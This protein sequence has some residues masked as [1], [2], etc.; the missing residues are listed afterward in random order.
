[1]QAILFNDY[2]ITISGT[3]RQYHKNIVSLLYIE[4]YYHYKTV[5]FSRHNF[6]VL[7]FALTKL[8]K[9]LYYK[10]L[11]VL[12]KKAQVVFCKA[13]VL[14]QLHFNDHLQEICNTTSNSSL[15]CIHSSLQ[16]DFFCNIYK[17]IPPSTK[18]SGACANGVH[19]HDLK[20]NHFSKSRLMQSQRG[21]ICS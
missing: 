17:A 1:M 16:L 5:R 9:K 13:L 4:H 12:L 3:L 11:Q 2:K 6:Y 19:R 10:V 7:S 20:K 15:S 8:K 21:M 14:P 18:V